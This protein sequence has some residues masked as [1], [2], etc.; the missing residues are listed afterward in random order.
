VAY[1]ASAPPSGSNGYY[2]GPYGMSGQTPMANNAAPSAGLAGS[3]YGA[4]NAAAPPAYGGYQSPYGTPAAQQPG[5]AYRTADTRNA[6]SAAAPAAGY[7]GG[8]AAT[9]ANAWNNEQWG[10]NSSQPAGYSESVQPRGFETPSNYSNPSIAPASNPATSSATGGFRPG[11]TGRNT[12]ALTPGL[13]AA[14]APA[15]SN[16]YPAAAGYPTTSPANLYPDP[17]AGAAR[18][19][20][21]TGYAGGY[22]YPS[23]SQL[24]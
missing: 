10:R 9:G 5:S 3:G 21:S 2:T 13:S 7:Y 1:N 22:S 20:N 19:A 24:R 17:D 15:S 8:S 14:P 12:G 11:S 16:V 23:T 4:A 18:T 6:A